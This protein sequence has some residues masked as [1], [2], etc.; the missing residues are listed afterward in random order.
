MSSRKGSFAALADGLCERCRLS[1][2]KWDLCLERFE[3]QTSEHAGH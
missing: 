1:A 2:I 3:I